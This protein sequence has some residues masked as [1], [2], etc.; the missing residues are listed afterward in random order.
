V[1]EIDNRRLARL[2]KLAG[3][4][5]APTAGVELLVHLGDRVEVDQPV[6]YVHAEAPGEL[7][8]ALTYLDSHPELIV[9]EE[10]A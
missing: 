1:A 3:A 4:P 8:Y 7:A 9:V 6:L 5:Q 2:A 10:D